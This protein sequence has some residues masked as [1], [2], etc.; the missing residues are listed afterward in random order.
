MR[1]PRLAEIV[2]GRLRDDILTGR[3]KEGDVIANQE[4]LFSEY[5]VSLPAL[6]EAM[7]I[8][9]TDGLITVRRGNVGGAV[10]HAPSPQRA[11][12]MIAM[13]LQTRSSSPAD[14]SV[15]LRQLE[16][17]CVSLCAAREDRAAT[18]L[19]VLREIVRLQREALDE[20][21]EFLRHSSDFH[22]HLVSLCGNE[23]LI[24]V[25]GALEIIWS[26]HESMVWQAVADGIDTEGDPAEPRARAKRAA[27]LRE[28]DELVD[29]IERGDPD[30]AAAL[31]TA[32]QRLAHGNTLRS[33]AH[34]TIVASLVD[35]LA[36]ATEPRRGQ[37]Q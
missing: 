18:V 23:P 27:A 10:V 11:A 17:A 34:S 2:A 22:S 35:T 36:P 37:D 8:L 21:A 5:R 32:H 12:Q 19:P 13:V 14:I 20:R 25:T 3:L 1:Q 30:R 16:P 9:E 31:A 28:H 29:A 26:A 33:G 4:R 7:R 24:V 6:R 15:A